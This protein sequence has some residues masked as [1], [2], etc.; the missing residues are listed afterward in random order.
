M[1]A[2]EYLLLQSFRCMALARAY[3]TTWSNW[4]SWSI[5]LNLEFSLLAPGELFPAERSQL[6]PTLSISWPSKVLSR[7]CPAPQAPPDLNGG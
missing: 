2:L 3:F 6:L 1:G 7:G 4:S 5:N